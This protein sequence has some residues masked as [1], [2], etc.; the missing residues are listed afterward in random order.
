MRRFRRL[1]FVVLLLTVPFQAALGATGMLCAPADHHPQH[2]AAVPHSH[3]LEM[4]GDHHADGSIDSPHHA[5]AEPVSHDSH[6]TAGK[7]KVCSESCCSAAAIVA[8]QLDVILSDSP[9]RVSPT[10][11]PDLVSRSG[12]GL[13][14][15]P[16]TIV[17]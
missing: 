11:D 15:P 13:F 9:L 10:I 1:V 5:A 6:D 16:R 4:A 2:A 12:D 17:A 3:G 14:R 8:T 7:C